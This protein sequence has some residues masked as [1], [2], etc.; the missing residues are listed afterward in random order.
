MDFWSRDVENSFDEM[1]D[2]NREGRLDFAEQAYQQD[3]I[4]R[5][6]EDRDR[7]D[8]MWDKFQDYFEYIESITEK[9]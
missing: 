2:L 9:F 6:M 7:S 5:D 3:F 4:I 8:L 1:F